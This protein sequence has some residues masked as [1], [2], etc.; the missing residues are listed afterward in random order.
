MC[1]P[2]FNLLGLTIPEESVTKNF[3]LKGYGMTDLQGKSSLAPT[4]SKRGY[5]NEYVVVK[6]KQQMPI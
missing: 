3:N 5:K 2:S 6:G 4:F 1:V